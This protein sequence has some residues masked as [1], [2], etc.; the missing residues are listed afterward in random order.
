LLDSDI[1]AAFEEEPVAP[2]IDEVL[3]CY[4]GITASRLGS[5]MNYIAWVPLS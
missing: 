4:A 5:L 1:Q 2:S 3:V